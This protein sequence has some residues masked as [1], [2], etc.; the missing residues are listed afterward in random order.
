[1]SAT[2]LPPYQQIAQEL[3]QQSLAVTPAEMQGL[4]IGM[5]CGGVTTSEATWQPMLFD[6]TNDGMGWPMSALN[7]ANTVFDFASNELG[8][9]SFELSMLLP[10]GDD[11]MTYA[12]AVT[13]WVNHFISGVG[14]ANAKLNKLP[15]DVKEAM[16]DLEEIS[17]L[18][19]DENDDLEEQA[20]LLEQVLEH[21]KACVL[22]V[23]VELARQTKPSIK[24]N[25]KPKLH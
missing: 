8:D 16:G 20:D 15:A 14:L 5:I 1:M 21:V 12:D 3:S 22:T 11:L 17:K 4:L 25:S 9:G 2:S 19:I 13:E 7:Y 23:Y 18:G 6:Y 10:D 24:S